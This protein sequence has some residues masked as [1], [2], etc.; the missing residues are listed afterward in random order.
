MLKVPVR[1]EI[2]AASTKAGN[3]SEVGLT[4]SPALH[5]P[6]QALGAESRGAVDIRIIAVNTY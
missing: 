6:A 1:R 3:L 5:S 4:T 2:A